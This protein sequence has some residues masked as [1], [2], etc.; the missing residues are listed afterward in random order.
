MGAT[1]RK[2]A[3]PR[4]R[5]VVAL[6]PAPTVRA[7]D[8]A[9][10]RDIKVPVTLIVGEADAEAPPADGTDWLSAINPAFERLGLGAEVGHYTLLGGPGQDAPQNDTLFKDHP[11]VD[12]SMVH[13]TVSLATI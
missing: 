2:L 11:S 4:I 7:F 12:R 9:S 3:C 5:S 6:A 10:V 8:P 13:N 1:R